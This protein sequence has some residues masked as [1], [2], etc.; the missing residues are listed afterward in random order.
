MDWTL[1]DFEKNVEAIKKQFNIVG[2]E[3]E[4][5]EVLVALKRNKHVL[6]EGPVGVGKT[7]GTQKASA[8]SY[9]REKRN[10]IG[11]QGRL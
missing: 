5:G 9:R 6:L 8:I 11:D 10:R 3:R 1:E 7:T 2:R 4:L